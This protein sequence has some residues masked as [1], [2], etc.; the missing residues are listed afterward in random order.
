MLRSLFWKPYSRL[1]VVGDNANWS[2][3]E[4]AKQLEIT[5]QKLGIKTVRARKMDSN[6]EQAVH[7]TSQF[8]L[9]HNAP[10]RDK[11]RIS[12]DYFHGKPEHGESYKKC[13][14]IIGKQNKNIYRVRVATREMEKIIKE[15]GIEPDKVVR[16]PI[17]VDLNLFPRQTV[18]NKTA[19]RNKLDVPQDA[20][21]IGSFVKDGD[22]WGEG[23]NPKAIK[24]PEIFLAVLKNLKQY[25][26]N[27][28]VLLS[29][30]A[31]GY[32]KQGLDELQIPYVHRYLSNYADISMLYDALD[33]YLINSREE[34]GPKAA[35]ESMAKGIPL[36]TT[37]VGQCA[38][39]IKSGENAMMS[40]LDDVEGL[41]LSIREVLSDEKLREKIIQN[42][43]HT[44]REYSVENQLPLWRNYFSKLIDF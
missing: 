21:V 2:I 26:P 40:E 36:I 6:I 30:P 15:T 32:V 25:Y 4:E 37:R 14:E 39:L 31:R 33:L 9:L 17:G 29:G 5:A 24:A 44:A 19:A 34:G 22:G 28:F 20:L 7:F 41:G 38:D 10:E 16:I 27:I 13:L 35:F 42:G 18:E 8:S 3:D 12:L 11:N 23:L 43:F 1:I